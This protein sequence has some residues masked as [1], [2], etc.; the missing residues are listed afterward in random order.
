M[1]NNLEL[2]KPL[3]VFPKKDDSFYFIQILQRKKDNPGLRMSGS[4]NNS[5]TI[6]TYYINSIDKLDLYWEEMVKLA[7]L[8]NARVSINLN[9]RSFEKA[10]FQVMSKIAHQMEN[11]DFYNIRNAYNSVLGNYHA[12]ID[13]RWLVDIDKE[14][15]DLKDKIV[16]YINLS[17]LMMSN[18]EKAGNYKILAEIPTK[19]G[20][21]IIC[22]PFNMEQFNKLYPNL[23]L[24]KNNPTLLYCP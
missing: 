24:H 4:N 12:E 3:L 16:Q 18:H 2:I 15:L 17:Y 9:P 22:N 11:K 10:A 14:E 8:F 7:D 13:K 6:K 19:S 21:H 20:I 23:E 5:R 1:V